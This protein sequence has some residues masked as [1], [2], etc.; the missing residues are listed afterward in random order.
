MPAPRDVERI[1]S[2][3]ARA[4]ARPEDEGGRVERR[5]YAALTIGGHQLAVPL[6][7]VV[8]AAA[9]RHLT[10][11]PSAP[12]YL[13]GAVAVEGRVVVLLDVARFLGLERRGLA[14][15]T[16]LLVVSHAGGE[17]G[18]A[19]E[20]LDGIEDIAVDQ[21]R[22]VPGAPPPIG[23]MAQVGGRDVLLLDIDLLCQDPRLSSGMH[24]G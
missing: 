9:L 10:E 20:H 2:E 13:V 1:L 21:P 5:T 15:L 17:I 19:A 3:R 6:E 12:P 14:D 7:R 22:R 4:L 23:E 8:R 16:G 24:D 11:V 18:L